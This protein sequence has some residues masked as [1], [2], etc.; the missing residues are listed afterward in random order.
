MK[1]K[2]QGNRTLDFIFYACFFIV[3][4]YLLLILLS[5]L[6]IQSDNRILLGIGA[7]SYIS[8]VLMCHQLP[9]RS[10]ELF[11]QYMPICSRD[12]ALFIGAFVA[13]IASFYSERL[14]NFMKSSWLAI[15]S[16][17][18]LGIDG[19]MQLLGFWES[20]NEIRL[21]TGL[22]AGFCISYYAV[23]VF[24]GQPRWSRTAL[25]AL[26]VPAFF[27][28]ILLGAAVYIGGNYQTKSEVLSKTKAINNATGIKV[29]YIAPRAFS[30][31]IRSD[32]YLKNYN[33]TVLSDVARIDGSSQY[34]VWVAVAS[35][36]YNNG[37][38]VF[39]SGNGNNY[40]Y[41]AMSGEL[42]AEFEH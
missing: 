34:G 38:Y 3:T 13:C 19:V 8:N 33:D 4:L 25:K 36:S 22:F 16:I 37:R 24:I 35:G 12:A 30:V 26:V 2:K 15:L 7:V 23:Y 41:D 27:L 29:F 39:A 40:F 18:P 5:P 28:V 11:G 6:F 42:M 1:S 10:F 17:V 21:L 9:E 32:E 31:S 20:T 14:P